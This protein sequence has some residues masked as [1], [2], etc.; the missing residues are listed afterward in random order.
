MGKMQRDVPRNVRIDGRRTSIRLDDE[1]WLAL[2][3]ICRAEGTTIHDLCT[4]IDARRG[5]RSLVSAVR[6]YVVL[7]FR[8]RLEAAE[9]PRPS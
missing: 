3:A 2:Q 9:A 1:M 6:V 8:R 5:E 7:Y 4:T